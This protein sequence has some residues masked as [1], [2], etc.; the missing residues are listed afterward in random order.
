MEF[1]YNWVRHW[2]KQP[3]SA[4]IEYLDGEFGF[5]CY[6]AGFNNTTWSITNCWLDHYHKHIW[7]N[8]A[9]VNRNFDEV[10]EAAEDMFSPLNETMEE[11]EDTVRDYE[12]RYA[13]PK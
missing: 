9:C 3:L 7:S 5:T 12:H 4:V 13:P 2:A 8:I 1:E 6:W 10:R 11:E